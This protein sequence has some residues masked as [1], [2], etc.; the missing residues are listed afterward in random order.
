MTIINGIIEYTKRY[1]RKMEPSCIIVQDIKL[2][3]A[4]IATVWL[5][6]NS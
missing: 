3:S 2:L 4:A 1:I 5:F 6:F